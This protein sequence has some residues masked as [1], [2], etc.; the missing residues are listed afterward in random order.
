MFLKTFNF[1]LILYNKCWAM[2]DIIVESFLLPYAMWNNFKQLLIFL[3][4][5]RKIFY[6]KISTSETVNTTW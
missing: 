6:R 5:L 4:L 2:K 3:S 1:K